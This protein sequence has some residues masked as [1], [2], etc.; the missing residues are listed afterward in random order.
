MNRVFSIVLLLVAMALGTACVKDGL[1]D[2]ATDNNNFEVT[3]L[4]TVDDCTVYRF[5]DDGYYHYV[6]HC[7][8][9]GG[10]TTMR[11]VHHTKTSTP[12]DDVVA[13]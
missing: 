13:P 3:R 12:V 7:Q 8:N 9:G 1:G 4:F 5:R 6:A 10:A 2:V 11:V